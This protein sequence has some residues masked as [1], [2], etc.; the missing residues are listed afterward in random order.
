MRRLLAALLGAGLCVQAHAQTFPG[1]GPWI[2]APNPQTAAY[3]AVISDCG[4][5]IALGGNALYQLTINNPANYTTDCVFMV[6]NTDTGNNKTVA[7]SGLSVVTLTPQQG[8]LIWRNASTWY[9][10]LQQPVSGGGGGGTPGGSNTQVQFNNSGAF[11]G[12][13]TLTWVSPTLTI[14]LQ[15]SVVGQLAMAGGSG[16]GTATIQMPGAAATY[17]FNLPLGAGSGGQPLLSGGGG[18][19]PQAYSPISYPASAVSGGVPY[20]SSTSQM[21]SSG[22]LT[23]NGVVYGGG[24]G[25]A[26]AS[27]TAGVG[28]QL[29][30]GVTSAPPNFAQ[31]SQDCTITSLGVITCTRT[32]NVLFGQLATQAVPC[33][34]PQG[35]TGQITAPAARQASGLNVWGDSSTP[36]GDSNVA[37]ASTE[38]LAFTNAA[39]TTARTWTLPAASATGASLTIEIADMFGGVTNV[40]TL[41]ILRAGSDT[42][43]GGTSVAISATNGAY[44]CSSDGVSRW[45]C[46]STGAASAGGV[47]SITAGYGLTG[48]VITTSGTITAPL[49]ASFAQANLGGL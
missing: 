34:I 17:N 35:C 48:G 29:L 30:L 18:T 38:R 14:G 1:V 11:G 9:E 16:A 23:Q 25:A 15:G 4:S 43:N 12:N 46:Q 20:F 32:G 22:L 40:N 26:P 24:A 5:T 44:L 21:T 7:A 13:P 41:T 10:G 19:N 2:N 3:T 45:T 27:T 39:F 36:H 33:T 8:L 28:G 37:I 31:M 49:I 47:S 42:I 6:T